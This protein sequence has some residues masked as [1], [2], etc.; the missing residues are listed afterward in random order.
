MNGIVLL[1]DLSRIGQV[2]IA[3]ASTEDGILT[4]QVG[5]AHCAAELEATVL[6]FLASHGSPFLSAAAIS[7]PGWEHAGEQMMPNHGYSFKRDRIR[8]ICNIQRLH[9]VNAS[10][11]R[12]LAIPTLAASDVE[13]ICGDEPDPDQPKGMVGTGPGLGLAVLVP[14]T[15]GNGWTAFAGAGGHSDLAPVSDLEAQLLAIIARKY[16]HVSRERV[17]SLPGLIEIWNA[18]S[19]LEGTSLN[20]PASAVDVVDLAKSG[21]PRAKQVTEL[22]IGWLAATA[23]DLVLIWGARGGAY[24]TGELVELLYPQMDLEAFRARY[25]NKGR[26][27]EYIAE[28]PVFYVNSANCE[29]LGLSTLFN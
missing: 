24:L 19:V 8:Q 27:S 14:S 3:L 12:A 17:V 20:S 11:A 15:L 9:I 26:L 4:D 23:S 7:A 28:T 22:C 6:D 18:L 1:L 21:N 5:R 10:L 29:L 16:G 2:H 13:R 25:A